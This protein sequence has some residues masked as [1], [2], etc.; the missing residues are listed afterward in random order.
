M[1][2]IHCPYCGKRE[3]NEFSC[4]GEAHIE[5]PKNPKDLTDKQ[6]GDYVFFRTN[7]KG[8]QLE[9]WTHDTGCRR[10]FNVARDTITDQ[11]VKIYKVGEKYQ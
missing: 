6:W 1:F 8:I 3:V 4:H 2:Q 7:K 9:R 5:R 10:W 11:I